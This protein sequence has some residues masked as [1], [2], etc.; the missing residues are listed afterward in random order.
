M[1]IYSWLHPLRLTHSSLSP[2][3]LSYWLFP[4]S[5]FAISSPNSISLPYAFA[6]RAYLF[7]FLHT[8]PLAFRS[9]PGSQKATR[10]SPWS[11]RQD[12]Y[13][14]DFSD[15]QIDSHDGKKT[16]PACCL[17]D[18]PER[19]ADVVVPKQEP[20]IY[21]ASRPFALVGRKLLRPV[22][23]YGRKKRTVIYT[24]SL[25]HHGMAMRNTLNVRQFCSV[26]T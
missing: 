23:L 5:H 6:L 20:L 2:L 24:S 11:L 10:D 17:R 4:L 15:L 13:I 8:L 16:P 9:S 12:E 18:N 7:T 14:W 3:S 21:A 19:V 1:Y 26:G 25:F 22:R